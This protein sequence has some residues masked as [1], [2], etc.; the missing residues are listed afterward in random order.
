M[1]QTVSVHEVRVGVQETEHRA[2][3]TIESRDN[4]TTNAPERD[5]SKLVLFHDSSLYYLPCPRPLPPLH[6][7][8]MPKTVDTVFY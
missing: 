4:K 6:P 8:P 3:N 2:S 1:R 5:I 7:P